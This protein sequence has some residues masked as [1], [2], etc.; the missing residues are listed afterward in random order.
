MLR[1]HRTAYQPCEPGSHSE[2]EQGEQLHWHMHVQ[3]SRRS[4]RRPCNDAMAHAGG[5]R[6]VWSIV[7]SGARDLGWLLKHLME[8]VCLRR[9]ICGMCPYVQV[10]HISNTQS[11]HVNE[12]Q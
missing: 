9:C 3:G 1:M 10:Q 7:D 5:S 8:W 11:L 12:S 2:R 4:G 6:G